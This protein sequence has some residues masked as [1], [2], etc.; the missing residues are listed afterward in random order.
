MNTVT[1]PL[2]YPENPNSL[3]W[4]GQEMPISTW[5][6]QPRSFKVN[7]QAGTVEATWRCGTGKA[8]MG[9]VRNPQSA[10]QW[11]RQQSAGSCG[12]FDGRNV[13]QLPNGSNSDPYPSHSQRRLVVFVKRTGTLTCTPQC[14]ERSIRGVRTITTLC[15]VVKCRRS[16]SGE[17]LYAWAL[18]V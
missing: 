16:N 17:L 2:R 6:T 12:S 18:K 8:R 7:I 4:K 3:R 5:G 11:M 1:R 15:Q 9:W 13:G 14:T 10:V